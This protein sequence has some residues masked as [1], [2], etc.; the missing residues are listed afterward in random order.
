[1]VDEFESN[2]LPDGSDMDIQIIDLLR[3]QALSQIFIIIYKMLPIQTV[4]GWL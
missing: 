1:M 3:I 2:F 4:N